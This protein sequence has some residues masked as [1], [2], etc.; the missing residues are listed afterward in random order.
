MRVNRIQS[1]QQDILITTVHEQESVLE[2][3]LSK[4]QDLVTELKYLS[5]NRLSVYQYPL[6][7]YMSQTIK[8]RG[9]EE[10]LMAFAEE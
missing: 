7:D 5:N 1:D 8:A 10:K 4:G 3:Y 6:E 2:V 9:V